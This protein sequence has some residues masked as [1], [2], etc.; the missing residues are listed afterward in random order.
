MFDFVPS[1]PY[2]LNVTTG[3]SVRIVEE[4]DGTGW[5]KVKNAKGQKGLVPATYVSMED[6][7]SGPP[8]YTETAKP[9]QQGSGK[10][11]ACRG[12]LTRLCLVGL[13]YRSART[14]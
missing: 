9:R 2:E 11:G 5:V 10:F 3:D 13:T 12:F 7:S 14:V 1:S 4:D 6:S 8:V